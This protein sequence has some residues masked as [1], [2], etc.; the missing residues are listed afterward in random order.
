MQFSCNCIDYENKWIPECFFRPDVPKV[1]NP[2]WR[3]SF[4]PGET[5]RLRLLV[6]PHSSLGTSRPI[7]L[8]SNLWLGGAQWL[9]ATRGISCSQ[10]VFLMGSQ[11]S[12]TPFLLLCVLGPLVTCYHP[13]HGM[14]RLQ[15]TEL[16]FQR[17]IYS[18]L[19]R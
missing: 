2:A 10:H 11:G 9:T 16:N 14:F 7:L 12:T 8:L 15:S 3:P 19:H 17:C 5:A 13:A 4:C 18:F 1:W 6:K